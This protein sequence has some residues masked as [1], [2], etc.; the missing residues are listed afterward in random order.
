MCFCGILL[1]FICSVGDCAQFVLPRTKVSVSCSLSLTQQAAERLDVLILNILGRD[2][3]DGSLRCST[4]GLLRQN[5][6]A[7]LSESQHWVYD[8]DLR[9]LDVPKEHHSAFRSN[10]SLSNG[11]PSTYP[12]HLLRCDTSKWLFWVPMYKLSWRRTSDASGSDLPSSPTKF[13]A[14]SEAR[15]TIHY[16]YSSSY[17]STH[18][19]E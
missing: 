1:E 2:K 15:L 18:H 8:S 6:C 17:R 19:V 4:Q 3:D 16:T 11:P 13:L 10:A 9:L 12:T 5:C 7:S 14:Q